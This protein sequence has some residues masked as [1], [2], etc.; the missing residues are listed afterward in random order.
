MSRI[1]AKIVSSKYLDPIVGVSAALIV[2]ELIS[3]FL[4][5]NY[6]LPAPSRIFFRMLTFS[7][8]WLHT[9]ITLNEV[10]LGFAT[11]IIGGILL[12]I[13]IA[14][15]KHL[16]RGLYPLLTFSQ[17]IPKSALAPL[18]IV[19]FG[20]GLLPKVAIAFL[21]TFF[22]ILVNSLNGLVVTET[23]LLDLMRS[24]HASKL[25]ILVK[26]RL[27]RSLPFIF[28][29]LEIAAPLSVIGAVI[30]EFIAGDRGLGYLVML[31]TYLR[32]TPLLFASIVTMAIIGLV[33][34]W[35][36]VI[37]ERFLLPW[38]KKV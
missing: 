33:M 14:H 28:S 3:R 37:A 1:G 31:A 34:F 19:W 21:I 6:L 9:S 13:P 8:M 38:Y 36:V 27:P 4:V 16:Q 5:P 7:A 10:L 18:F 25:Q 2:W 29:G 30:A 12:A 23:E 11:G 22:P 17:S 20:L 26:I 24:L 32:D 15:S 35:A